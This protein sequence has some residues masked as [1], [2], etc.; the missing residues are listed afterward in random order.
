MAAWS[1][2]RAPVLALHGEFDWIMSREDFEILVALVNR[3]S[4][5]AAEF[6]ELA[7][8]GHTFEHYASLKAAFAGEQLPFDPTVAARITSWFDRHR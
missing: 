2:V 5:G 7:S 8:T 6:V 3:N 4:P 1:E